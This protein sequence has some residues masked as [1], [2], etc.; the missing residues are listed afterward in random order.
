MA[1]KLSVTIDPKQLS[2]GIITA[3]RSAINAGLHNAA[4]DIRKQL[5]TTVDFLLADNP[6]Y[7]S[8]ASGL[9]KAEFGLKD[10]VRRIKDIAAAIK[11]SLEVSVV[12][13]S[14]F[15]NQLR[16]G[17]RIVMLKSDL[18]DILS[19]EAASYQSTSFEVPWLEWLLTQGDRIIVAGYNINYNVS[20]ADRAAS[21]SGVAIM[22]KGGGWRVPPEFAGTLESNWIT[23]AFDGPKV[24]TL[25][26]LVV[27]KHLKRRLK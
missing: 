6:T 19:L 10:P 17:L 26:S 1:V 14:T 24:E 11:N 15:G 12:P 23:K 16:G 18:Q 8:L 2:H 7:H 3:T 27:E 22:E 20:P 9:L 21:R 5:L 13:V 25:I 4:I